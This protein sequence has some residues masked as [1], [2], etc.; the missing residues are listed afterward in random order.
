MMLSGSQC[1]PA[2]TAAWALRCQ[3]QA[4]PVHQTA[5][6]DSCEHA[7]RE[8]GPAV[9]CAVHA[10]AELGRAVQ[11]LWLRTLKRAYL[12]PQPGDAN[13]QSDINLASQ[14]INLVSPCMQIMLQPTDW[15]HASCQSGPV[16]GSL[17]QLAT[18]A[19]G[20]MGVELC[21]CRRT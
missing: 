6:P 10:M 9:W 4:C 14:Y 2:V 19:Q 18:R 3:T 15:K 12:R 11:M 8:S 7:L 17:V 21:S 1:C 20:L 16:A 5:G 13:N